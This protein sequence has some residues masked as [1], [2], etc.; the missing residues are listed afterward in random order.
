MDANQINER[1]YDTLRSVF[2]YRQMTDGEMPEI[3]I[4]AE[5]NIL[6]KHMRNLTASEMF[7]LVTLWPG[8]L[9]EQTAIT[10]VEDKRFDAYMRTVN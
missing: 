4:N 2:R 7:N 3:V 5:A 1:V 8:Y 9:A 10:E 6:E